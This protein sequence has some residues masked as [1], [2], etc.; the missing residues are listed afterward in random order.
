MNVSFTFCPHCGLSLQTKLFGQIARP[1]CLHCGFVQFPD[2]KVAVIGL[3][4]CE[5]KVLLSLRDVEPEKGK[6]S[7]PG[8]YMDAGEMPDLA[9]RREMREE[10]HLELGELVFHSFL[11][12]NGGRGIV[13]VY[14]TQPASGRCDPLVGYDDI[15]EA[16]WFAKELLPPQNRL[17]FETTISLLSWWQNSPL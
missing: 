3:I 2:P 15:A 16:Q 17:A 6:W 12:M 8:G 1:A 14:R 11:P 4:V 9:L 10:L 7:L 13:I 5:E